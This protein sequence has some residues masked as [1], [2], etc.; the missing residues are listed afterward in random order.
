MNANELTELEDNVEQ[1]KKDY[2]I[3]R[4]R[5]VWLNETEAKGNKQEMNK[6]RNKDMTDEQNGEEREVKKRRREPLLVQE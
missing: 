2:K 5:K 6:N 3:K 1:K 4:E